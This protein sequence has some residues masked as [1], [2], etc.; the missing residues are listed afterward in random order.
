MNCRITPSCPPRVTAP[1]CGSA[2]PA[3]IRNSV[4]LPVPLGPTRAVLLPSPTRRL[5][6]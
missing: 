6:S 3:I 2:S 4:V 5:T 1:S